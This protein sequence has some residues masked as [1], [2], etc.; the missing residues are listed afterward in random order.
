MN[1]MKILGIIISLSGLFM[2]GFEAGR[3]AKTG[4]SNTSL[5]F[6][7]LGIVFIG[8]FITMYL[9]KKKNA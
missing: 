3:N 7:G 8:L 2:M 5:T 1:K 4:E 6:A 9:S